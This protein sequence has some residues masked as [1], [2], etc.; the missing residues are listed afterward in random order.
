MGVGFWC[1]CC[2]KE[3]IW[4]KETDRRHEFTMAFLYLL[5]H[6][7]THEAFKYSRRG[8]VESMEP[9]E[10]GSREYMLRSLSREVPGLGSVI[11][12]I[13]RCRIDMSTALKEKIIAPIRTNYYKSPVGTRW[14]TKLKTEFLKPNFM[15]GFVKGEENWLF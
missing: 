15:R 2:A 4:F 10:A 5:K 1:F 6:D 3:I 13:Q 8:E 9:L 7:M 11:K 12:D 14:G